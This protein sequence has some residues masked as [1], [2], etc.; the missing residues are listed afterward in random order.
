LGK[1][2][3]PILPFPSE[4][5]VSR[6][7]QLVEWRRRAREGL[8]GPP[9]DGGPNLLGL[10]PVAVS[11]PSGAPHGDELPPPSVEA[12]TIEFEGFRIAVAPGFDEAHLVRV[13][14]GVRA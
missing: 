4:T 7:L 10:V 5:P 14:R 1:Q 8:L 13:L 2:P 9:G 3:T 6:S 11:A 12:V